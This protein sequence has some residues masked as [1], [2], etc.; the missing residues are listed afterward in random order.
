MAKANK[1]PTASERA[2]EEKVQVKNLHN[3]TVSPW[4]KAQ[5]EAQK[6]SLRGKYAEVKAPK[7]PPEVKKLKAKKAEVTEAKTTAAVADQ[8]PT[9]D[10]S[11]AE[12]K[13]E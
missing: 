4:P 11:S 7:E 1:K 9:A 13:T 2:K 6:A 8:Q 5:W 10:D 12:Q 3:N